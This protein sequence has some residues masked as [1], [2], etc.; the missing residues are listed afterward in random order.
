[1]KYLSFGKYLIQWI[2]QKWTL[3]CGYSH[4]FLVQ[5]TILWYTL[6]LWYKITRFVIWIVCKLSTGSL[7][8]WFHSPFALNNLSLIFPMVCRTLIVPHRSPCW[9]PTLALGNV[10]AYCGWSSVPALLL[11]PGSVINFNENISSDSSCYVHKGGDKTT[12]NYSSHLPWVG[13]LCL[14]GWEDKQ[15]RQKRL[16]SRPHELWA[17][18]IYSTFLPSLIT[19]VNQGEA[20]QC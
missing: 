16:M 17:K 20:R 13:L 10:G 1:M 5:I 14:I 4:W 6:L 2:I 19:S 15:R 8:K 7:I 11:L 9:R 12:R 18:S 3:P